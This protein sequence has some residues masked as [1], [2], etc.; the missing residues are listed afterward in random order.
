VTDF[1]ADL[2]LVA[3]DDVLMEQVFVNLVENAVKYTPAASPI[4]IKAIHRGEFIVVEVGDRGP[5]IPEGKETRIFEKFFRGRTDS[6]RGAG[7]GLAIC[8]AIVEAH[9]GSIEALNRS[10]GGA[11]FRMRLPLAPLEPTSPS[12][13][14]RHLG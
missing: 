13:E 9:E 7:L 10:G 3:I 4:E 5:G 8:R 1:P 11:L 6:V 12:L 14:R 2:P